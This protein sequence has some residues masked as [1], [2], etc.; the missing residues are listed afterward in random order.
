MAVML[1]VTPSSSAMDT[2]VT[3]K[4]AV[5]TLTVKGFYLKAANVSYDVY[6]VASDS[7]T[8]VESDKSIK[9]YK[10]EL[11]IGTSYMIL[12]TKDAVTKTLYV[13]PTEAG[14]FE[15]DVDFRNNISAELVFDPQEHT[16]VV[17]IIP[18]LDTY[19]GATDKSHP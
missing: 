10:V 1:L 17:H 5:T 19:A 16:Y 3:S 12:F 4:D 14:E 2:L 15:L 8:L 7:S 18:D 13:T 11:E 9:A 6:E